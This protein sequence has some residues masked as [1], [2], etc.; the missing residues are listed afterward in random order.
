MDLSGWA[1]SIKELAMGA[2]EVGGII[3]GAVDSF[4]GAAPAAATDGGYAYM[5][6]LRK[7]WEGTAAVPVTGTASYLPP[8]NDNTALYVIGAALLALLMMRR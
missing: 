1:T 4:A 8:S 7:G 2:K 3:K 6:P 5:A